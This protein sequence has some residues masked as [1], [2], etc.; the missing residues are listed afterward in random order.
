M[1][2]LGKL[3]TVNRS[4]STEAK[5][6]F[7]TIAATLTVAALSSYFHAGWMSA[8]AL[9][10]GMFAVIAVFAARTRDQFLFKLLAFGLMAGIVE[11]AADCWLV[12]STGT[13]LYA[14]TE[15][16]IFCS[17]IYM[18]F[19]WAVVLVQVGYLGWL[20]S[21]HKPMWQSMLATLVL[22]LLFIPLFEHFANGAGWW[23]Y[24]NTPMIWDTP[25]YIIMAEGLICMVLPF[26]FK[27]EVQRGYV[28]AL[29]FGAFQGLWIWL[30]YYVSF[31]VIG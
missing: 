16:M 3:G 11:L 8:A 29:L 15:P 31:S 27:F 26:L 14:G 24:Q 18:P 6:M 21:G 23:V 20:I 7:I 4:T 22:G 2:T 28:R 5:F 30:A 13:L 25:W 12:E 17:P 9:A 10:F 1:G 19:A